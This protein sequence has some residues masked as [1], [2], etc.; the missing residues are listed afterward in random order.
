[1]AYPIPADQL[2]EIRAL[3]DQGDPSSDIAQKYGIP[4]GSII[5]QRAVYKGEKNRGVD[6]EGPIIERAITTTF[7]LE[8]DLQR[9]LRN[10]IDQ[11]EKGLE[12]KDGG[13]ERTVTSGRIDITAKDSTGRIV[14]IELKAGEAD[15]DAIGQILAYMG[16]VGEDAER[17]VR[18]ILVAGA[19]STSAVAASRAV[20][21]LELK[22]YQFQFTFE[23]INSHSRG[24]AISI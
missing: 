18:G 19:F 4:V 6:D 9:A 23:S 10:N 15:R 12:I 16:D 17:P 2:L 14:V 20:P 22:R 8:R 13:K 1:M 21:N 24:S 11:L 3:F 7:G 5:A